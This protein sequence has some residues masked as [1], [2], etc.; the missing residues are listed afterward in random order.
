[1]PEKGRTAMIYGKAGIGKTSLLNTL[2]G[3]ILLVNIDCGE[4]VL[5]AKNENNNF[6]ICTL[7]SRKLQNPIESV[8]KLETF[9]DYLMKQETLPW[10]YICVDN[11]SE[12]EDIYADALRKKRN[13]V[14][15]EDFLNIDV[16]VDI[17]R[18]LKKI[19]NIT[20][21]GPD[22]LYLAWEKTVKITDSDGEVHSEKGP[23][24]MGTTQLKIEGLVDFVLAM[25]VDKKGERYLQLDADHKYAAKKREE[26]GRYYPS[27]IECP[28][29][30]VG[31]LQGL[32][33]MI[34]GR[35]NVSD[36]KS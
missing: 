36:S 24:I 30:G 16:G 28:K 34:H 21:L 25:R 23:M 13:Q 26:P 27:I 8:R 18:I 19:R 17:L 6:D 4:Q 3:N 12:L 1:M 5:D 35:N 32:F 31:T 29:E 10:D 20:Y 15:S 11:V 22:V 2:T 33:D 14:Y 9:I 7:V